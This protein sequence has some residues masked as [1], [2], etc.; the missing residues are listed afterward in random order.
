MLPVALRWRRLPSR[1]YSLRTRSINGRLAKAATFAAVVPLAARL[2]PTPA[3]A[4]QTPALALV[5]SWA[6]PAWTLGVL[7]FSFRMVWG[8]AQVAALQRS[9][10]GGRRRRCYA[11]VAGLS[12]RMGLARPPRVLISEWAG[13]PSV[14]GWL[15]PVILL[16]AATLS[17]L[18]PEQLEAM[19][20]HELAHIRRHDYLVNWLQMLVETLLF[21]HPAVWWISRRI[22]HERELCCDDLAVSACGAPCATPAR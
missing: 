5:Q 9:G 12:R 16:P 18:T 7:L 8:C 6:L 1:R 14:V 3:P 13:G 22:R 2:S 20:A 15:R 4:H 19:L 17:G 10:A 11:T 21:Y